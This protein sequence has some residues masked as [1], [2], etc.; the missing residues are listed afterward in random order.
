MRACVQWAGDRLFC[1]LQLSF[2]FEPHKAVSQPPLAF[3]IQILYT[4]LLEYYISFDSNLRESK[5][6][7]VG[8]LKLSSHYHSPVL[9]RRQ[10]PLSAVR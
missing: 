4:V 5:Q 2:D 3:D 6:N 7:G 1:K 10:Q 8:Q 9:P